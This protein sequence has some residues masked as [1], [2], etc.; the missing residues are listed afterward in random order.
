M[1]VGDAITIEVLSPASQY[2]EQALESVPFRTSGADID[3]TVLCESGTTNR[4]HI[5]SP[6]GEVVTLDEHEELFVTARDGGGVLDWYSVQ[7][8]VC[9]DETGAFVLK[10]HTR[11][12]L[13]K[14]ANEQDTSTWVVES[15]TGDYTDLSGSGDATL[16][17]GGFPRSA[18]A[19]YTGEVQTG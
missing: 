9:D 13:A 3:D 12:D 14:P 17:L 5:E 18:A 7:E 1:L 6:E 4:D 19:V 8:F 10:V 16:I 15:G 11:I 2:G